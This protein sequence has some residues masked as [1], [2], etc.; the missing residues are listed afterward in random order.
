MKRMLA[1]I[2]LGVMVAATGCKKNDDAGN[3]DKT[4]EKTADKADKP[5]GGGEI[6]P[7]D[8]EA[9]KS[10]MMDKGMASVDG[11]GSAGDRA[12]ATISKFLG[13]TKAKINGLEGS[14]KANADLKRHSRT[15]TKTRLRSSWT[16]SARSWRPA[17]TTRP[18]RK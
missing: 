3:K 10:A 2:V 8:Y 4:A 5:A 7:A 15:R 16:A 11:L 14:E 9:R 6:T 18:C 12:P 1:T 17:R 13:D